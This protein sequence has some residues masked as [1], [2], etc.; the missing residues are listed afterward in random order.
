M[1]N[2]SIFTFDTPQE[3]VLEQMDRCMEQASHGVLCADNHVGY[4]A[5]IGASIAYPK[6]I[7]PS[8]VGYDIG[9]GNLA[10]KTT[11]QAKD[12]H[13]AEVMDEIIEVISF[14]MGRKNKQTVDHPVLAQIDHADF[15]PQRNLSMLAE[16]QLG[17]VGSG[18][19][20]VDL[21]VDESGALWVGCHFGSRGFGHK[22]ATGFLAMSQGK[23]FT[24]KAKDTGLDAPPT[25][26]AVDSE[27][28]QAYIAAMQLAGEYAYAGRDWVVRR[29][30]SL[31]NAGA[32]E[33]VHNHHNFAW[34]E[35]HFGENVWVV[36]KGA[37][38]AFPAQQGF[39]GAS[40]AGISVILEGVESERSQQAL[41]STVHGAGR[42]M[43]RTEAAGR[44]RWDKR[45]KQKVMKSA[46]RIDWNEVL[47]DLDSK[48]IELRGGGADEAPGAYKD[49]QD[50]LTYHKG[51]V[52]I[53]HQ[54]RPIG[55]AMA[56]AHVKD[57]FRD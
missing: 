51:T 26:F 33:Y 11:L 4:S 44:W 15:T 39:V 38:P 24:D 52:N 1:S 6:H 31:L 56:G 32:V 17:T 29:V 28:G 45:T 13:V 18:N 53:L 30:L 20:Y 10:V 22:T 48:G 50:V 21:F 9:C 14:G 34:R 43:S 2:T 23:D 19:H 57:P 5:P 49:L 42:K 7:S 35:T 8:G 41:Y 3:R 37:T 12:I 46:G 55:V 47:E 25:L 16:R 27:I 40:M 36:R 54:L